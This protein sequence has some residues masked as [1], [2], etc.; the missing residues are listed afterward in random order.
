MK[1]LKNFLSI[2]LA[3]I[4]AMSFMSIAAYAKIVK[5]LPNGG[6]FVI[7]EKG[8][9]LPAAAHSRTADFTFSQTF[10]KYPDKLTLQTPYRV[11]NISNVIPL[12]TGEKNIL[13]HFDES[14]DDC[15]VWIYNVD[16]GVYE[17]EEEYM[18]MYTSEDYEFRNFPTSTSYRIRFSGTRYSE[19]TLS[20]SCET[21]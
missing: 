6:E 16:E 9:V 4:S 10:P 18:G 14:P 12:S 1:K 13:F 11:N 3:T 21:Y 15:Y 2:G 8:D 20:G 17:L 7:Y 5:P 19:V